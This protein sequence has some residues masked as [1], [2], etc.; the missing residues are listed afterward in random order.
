MATREPQLFES[1]VTFNDS[2]R[3]MFTSK[4][5]LLARDGSLYG[6]GAVALDVT[7]HKNLERQYLQAQ[8]MEG[9]GR[10]AGG[11]AHDFN[12]LLT[13]ILLHAE[14]MEMDLPEH[15]PFLAGVRSIQA[16]A[17]RASALT[18]QLLAFARRQSSEPKLIGL[19][20]LIR[21]MGEMLRPM[22]GAQIEL[23]MRLKADLPPVTADPN[24]IEQVILNLVL[25]ARDAMPDGGN[26]YVETDDLWLDGPLH[27]GAAVTAGEYVL[28]SIRDTGVGIDEDVRAR[29]FEPFFSTKEVGK[30]T[31]LGLATCYGI[32]KQHDGTISVHSEVG[33]GTTVN[34]YLP[35][36]GR[37]AYDA[38][39]RTACP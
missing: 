1:T 18:G 2:P 26:L 36:A 20:D 16:A 14:M 35:R 22:V 6:V 17:T 39:D 29:M 5:P 12:N 21:N 8:K 37:G 24:Q 4:F 10:L 28:L 3:T 13:A 15:S 34:V 32:V 38:Q 33:L 30:G 9:I 25:N 27:D 7:E 19:N 31:G 11:I 23:S